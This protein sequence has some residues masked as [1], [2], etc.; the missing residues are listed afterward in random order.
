MVGSEVYLSFA[1]LGASRPPRS[2][3]V[4]TTCRRVGGR[5]D[6]LCG[7]T[8]VSVNFGDWQ[9]VESIGQMGGQNYLGANLRRR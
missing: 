2:V 4:E 5:T 3:Q 6:L 7:R 8:D 1:R 9:L